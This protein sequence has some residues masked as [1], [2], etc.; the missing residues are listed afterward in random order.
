MI[1]AALPPALGTSNHWLLVLAAHPPPRCHHPP[2]LVK[3]TLKQRQ[4]SAENLDTFRLKAAEALG[5]RLGE[6]SPD[7]EAGGPSSWKSLS[8]FYHVG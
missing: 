2:Q 4:H 8:R 6:I 3:S 1:Q 5:V 7:I